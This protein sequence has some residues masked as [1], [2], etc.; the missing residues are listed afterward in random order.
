MFVCLSVRMEQLGSY[1]THFHEIWYLNIF[2]KPAENIQ[3]SLNSDKNNGHCTWIPIYIFFIISR[4]VL[5]NVSHTVVVKI[6]THILYS[7]KSPLPPESR[8]VCGLMWKNIVE[9]DRT[10][11]TIWRMRTAC[12]ITKAT[13]TL[14]EYVI[15][16]FRGPISVVGIA[17]GYGL[18][19][20]GIESR[21]GRDFPHLSRP[22]LE[23]TQPPVQWV[24]GLSRG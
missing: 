24:P 22:A 6:K 17:T 1:G 23:P 16:I 3:V 9:R 5:R 21:W 18:D 10:Q 7:I 13:N 14:S 4:S 20:P 8:A 15:L 2:R 11:M 19:S 12:W